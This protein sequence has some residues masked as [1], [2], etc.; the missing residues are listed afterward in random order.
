MSAPISVRD[1]TAAEHLAWLRTQPS[2]SFLQ[3]PAWADVKKEWRSESVG[4]F[5]GEQ[6]V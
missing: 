6:M 1:I 3:T 2:A 4:W 5:E